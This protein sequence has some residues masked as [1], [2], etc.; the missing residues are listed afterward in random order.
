M[1]L[2]PLLENIFRH[3]V[4]QRR[5]K[6]TIKVIARRDGD[7]LL[8][9]LEDDI[10]MLLEKSEGKGIG[11]KNLRT[12]LHTLY[13]ECASLTLIQLQPAGVRAEMRLPCAC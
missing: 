10:G 12:R 11:V 2:Q 9:H 6:T 4:E 5:Q 7:S 3:T 13:G 1:S 8:L